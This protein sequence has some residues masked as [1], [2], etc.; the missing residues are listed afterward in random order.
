MRPGIG[1]EVGIGEF[2]LQRDIKVFDFTVFSRAP[3]DG[4]SD[5]YAHTRYEFIEQM[6]EEISRRVLPYNKQ[7]QYIPTQI[8]AEYLREY[9]G[10]EAVIYRSSMVKEPTAENRNIVILPRAESFV[11]GDAAV[12]KY[13]RFDVME[14][15][16]VTYKLGPSF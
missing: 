14:V 13:R 7:L 16:D 4:G 3:A 6:E 5:K 9:F 1:E 11:G 15:L 12:L 10:C 2:V 8:V